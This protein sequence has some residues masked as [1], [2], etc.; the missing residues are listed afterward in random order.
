VPLPIYTLSVVDQAFRLTIIK[1]PAHEWPTLVT[2]LDQ[3]SRVNELVAGPDNTLV[4]TMDMNLY[5]KTMKLAY[6]DPQY[7]EK[8]VLFP[9]G[10][11]TV[12]CA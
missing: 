2:A 9:R 3:L 10:F 12:L 4:A 8:W 5:K 1:A 11:H 7:K 6:L